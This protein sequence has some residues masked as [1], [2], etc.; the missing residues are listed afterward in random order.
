MD[1]F[2]LAR[3]FHAERVRLDLTAYDLHALRYRGV[4]E[5]AWAGCTDEEIT[6]YSGHLSLLM[7]RKYAGKA[8]QTMRAKSAAEKRR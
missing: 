2:Y 3:T 5:L 8:R 7:I 6:S 4:M 1:Y